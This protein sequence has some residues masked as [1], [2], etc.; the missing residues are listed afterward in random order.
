MIAYPGE[1]CTHTQAQKLRGCHKTQ[2]LKRG[3]FCVTVVCTVAARLPFKFQGV[4]GLYRP[5]SCA[6]SFDFRCE[7][8]YLH[9]LRICT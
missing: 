2:S 3:C 4:A 8:K 1:H 7:T 5:A 9:R 6:A